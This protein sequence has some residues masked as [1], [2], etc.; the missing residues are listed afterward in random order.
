VAQQD[1]DALAQG[2]TAA[3]IAVRVPSAAMRGSTSGHPLDNPIWMALT[4]RHAHLAEGGALARR[5][6]ADISPLAGLPARGP[7]NIAALE[8][9]VEIGD[10]AGV[11]EAEPPALP[12]T[13]EVLRETRI[14][15]MVRPA[16]APLPEADAGYQPLGAADVA[17]MLDLVA[18]A[19]PGPFRTRTIELG[20]FLGLR[21]HGRLV[22]M[23]GER[24][25]IDGFREVSAIC[26][27][28]DVRGRGHARALTACV[29]NRML[30]HGETPFLHVL[31]AN[32]AA[33]ELYRALGFVH[34]S[35]FFLLHARRAEYERP[36]PIR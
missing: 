1:Q 26:T 7:A 21:E 30:A 11:F 10:E 19:Q 25:W 15:Q 2:K 8:A 4:T 34:R 24:M 36:R 12:A 33:I 28:P 13:W 22:A 6:P 5:Y 31:S 27:H 16:R 18:L 29:V 35:E 32:E 20:R 14:T 3:G 9:L 23:A 17:D